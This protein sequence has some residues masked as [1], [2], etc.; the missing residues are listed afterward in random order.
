MYDDIITKNKYINNDLK[1]RRKLLREYKTQRAHKMIETRA[2]QDQNRRVVFD[3]SRKSNTVPIFCSLL[4][5][6]L[7]PLCNVLIINAMLCSTYHYV[8]K[9]QTPLSFFLPLPE[10]FNPQV[11]RLLLFGH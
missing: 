7:L 9:C 8:T 11:F 6:L 4:F 1:E 2:R 10:S 5:R 3:S